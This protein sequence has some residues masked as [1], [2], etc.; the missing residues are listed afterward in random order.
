MIEFRTG[1]NRRVL[2]TK[3]Y[4]IKLPRVRH[5]ACGMRSNRWEREMWRYWRRVFPA[6]EHLCPIVFADR[7]G[8]VVVMPRAGLPDDPAALDAAVERDAECYPQPTVEFR[9]DEYGI[10]ADRVVCFDYGLAD[11]AMVRVRRE[12]YARRSGQ[13]STR[14]S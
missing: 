13:R 10:V 14:D 5:P 11:A 3:R 7:Y 1:S 12:Y 4:A 9:G 6:W 8:F 2:L